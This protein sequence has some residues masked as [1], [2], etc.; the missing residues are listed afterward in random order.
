[1]VLGL[2]ILG[3]GS[4]QSYKCKL[5][6]N[7]M[8]F[9]SDYTY[10]LSCVGDPCN[11]YTIF[12][13]IRVK[14]EWRKSLVR[15]SARLIYA[16]RANVLEAPIE[17]SCLAEEAAIRHFAT[18]RLRGS[19]RPLRGILSVQIALVYFEQELK[20][21]IVSVVSSGIRLTSANQ[22]ILWGSISHGM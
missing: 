10:V 19:W 12:N 2:V 7:M 11:Y 16:Q 20:Y 13:V 6:C 15:L 1:M 5:V 22:L 9:S 3:P 17:I 4:D 8:R 14:G 21:I 18:P